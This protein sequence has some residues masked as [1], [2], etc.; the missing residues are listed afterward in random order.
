M[1]DLN[2]ESLRHLSKLCRIEVS[3]EELPALFTSLKRVLDYADLLQS[4]DVSHLDPYSHMDEQGIT[5][6]RED[7]VKDL[8]PR[9]AF[10]NNAPDHVAGMIRVPT[11][12]KQNP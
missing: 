11:V 8:L 1:S 6:L 4:V 10:L 7:E 3:D 9:E 12:M 5:S 2:E